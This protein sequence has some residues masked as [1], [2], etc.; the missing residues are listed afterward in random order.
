MTDWLC[1]V[2]PQL[3]IG[4]PH[5]YDRPRVCQAC[6]NRL[7]HLH[8]DLADAYAQLELEPSANRSDGRGTR[9][10]PLPLK[11]DTLDLTLPARTRP[12]SDRYGDQTGHVSV[13]AVLD[14]WARDWQDVRGQGETLPPPS[15]ANLLRWLT[16]RLDWACDRHP[17]V[18]E[19]AGELARLV[20]TVRRVAGLNPAPAELK[21]GV[22]CRHC[23]QLGLYQWPGSERIECGACPAL[24][25]V[26]EYRQ[27]A[28]LVA[29]WIITPR[30]KRVSA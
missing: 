26:G 20:A 3:R 30:R 15:V 21:Y 29:G 27:W 24:Y 25:T 16:D 13:A 7:A 28:E 2:C 17:A 23:G 14:T 22:P 5:A 10:P 1:C 6:R 8:D 12:V 11:V 9:T 18:D 4:P 19:Y